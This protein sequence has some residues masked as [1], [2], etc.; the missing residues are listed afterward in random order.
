[1]R[2]TLRTF[3]IRAHRSLHEAINHRTIVPDDRFEREFAS[4]ADRDACRKAEGEET[5][6][7]IDFTKGDTSTTTTTTTTVGVNTD[8]TRTLLPYNNNL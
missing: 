7:T 1:M 3:G 6:S 4:V 2:D 5:Q 8:V